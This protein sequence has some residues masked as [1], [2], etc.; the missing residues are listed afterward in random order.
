MATAELTIMKDRKMIED[1]I[2]LLVETD[3]GGGITIIIR[4][5]VIRDRCRRRFGMRVWDEISRE[6]NYLFLKLCE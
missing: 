4:R 5:T 6:D 3:M 2:I 1:T